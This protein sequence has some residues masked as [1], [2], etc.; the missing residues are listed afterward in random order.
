MGLRAIKILA[1]SILLM[2]LLISPAVTDA[3]VS[4]PPIKLNPNM[5]VTVYPDGSIGIN[6]MLNVTVE[7]SKATLLGDFMLDLTYAELKEGL[8][9]AF[10]GFFDLY[11][12]TLENPIST[13]IIDLRGGFKIKSFSVNASALI[14]GNAYLGIRSNGEE[15]HRLEIKSLSIRS[16]PHIMYI[17][18]AITV[19]TVNET[20]TKILRN[21]SQVDATNTA[22]ERLI[23]QNITFI[24]FKELEVKEVN[25][26]FDING[27]LTIN[28]EDLLSQGV[29]QGVFNYEDV[30]TVRTC[31]L[32]T[33]KDLD[34]SLK[35]ASSF[36]N[37]NYT[38]GS[39]FTGK[40][41]FEFNLGGNIEG[42]KH[43]SRACGTAMSK[44]GY[45]VNTLVSGTGVGEIPTAPP[46][47]VNF[48]VINETISKMGIGEVKLERIL[49]FDLHFTLHGKLTNDVYMFILSL[50]VSRLKYP[51]QDGWKTVA[52]K[53]LEELSNFLQNVSRKLGFLELMGIGNPIPTNVEVYGGKLEDKWVS[54]NETIVSIGA[55]PYVTLE[56]KSITTTYTLPKPPS[57]TITISTTK[58]LIKEV[59][60][61]VTTTITKTLEL[62]RSLTETVTKT[63]ITTS[64]I[65]TTVAKPVITN[66]QL[67]LI[68]ATILAIVFMLLMYKRR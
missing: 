41:E 15:L 62:T 8:R 27:E 7:P 66:T 56:L 20:L 40:F 24:S 30:E 61:T 50:D 54:V 23:K 45:L 68:I 44:L 11:N 1:L 37:S 63:L 5:K 28:I 19:K 47:Q 2:V 55:L 52:K 14:Y 42:F 33:Y 21:V 31:L 53:S 4:T 6:Y 36:I 58:T 22:N 18:F 65:T 48:E 67:A 12:G 60:K 34:G 25:G 26:V 39:R 35:F 16:Q 64:Y 13:Q 49:P 59:E 3:Q 43:Y 9:M 51:M 38:M 17:T 29:K 10:G 46:T 32:A 57:L